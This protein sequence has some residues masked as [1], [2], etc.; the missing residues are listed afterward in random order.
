MLTEWFELNK[1]DNES[2]SLTYAQIPSHF[3]WHSTERCWA[4]RKRGNRIGRIMY[5]HPS[6]GERYYLRML[7]N[8]VKGATSFEDI[9]TVNGV[10]HP[11]FRSACTALGLLGDDKEWEELQHIR[12]ELYVKE[13]K[14]VGYDL[15]AKE[16]IPRHGKRNIPRELLPSQYAFFFCIVHH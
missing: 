8:V 2:R 15:A 1:H 6:A 4:K 14:N 3:V 13:W 9:R 16:T 11:T 7:L 12:T 5:V 10:L